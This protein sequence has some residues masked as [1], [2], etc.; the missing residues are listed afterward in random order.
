VN[1]MKKWITFGC[2]A[3][4]FTVACRTGGTGSGGLSLFLLERGM[5][6]LDTRKLPLQGGKAAGTAMITF[7]NV[8]CA[9]LVQV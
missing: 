2:Y 5:P 6:G 4:Y 1:G 8:V 7:D 9:Q 3:D